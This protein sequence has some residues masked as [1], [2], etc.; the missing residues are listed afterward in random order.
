M[1]TRNGGGKP[2]GKTGWE[3]PRKKLAEDWDGVGKNLE[4]W[5]GVRKILMENEEQGWESHGG[6]T[7]GMEGVG[8]GR[9]KRGENSEKGGK[10]EWEKGESH[11]G[12][13]GME[14]FGAGF[15]AGGV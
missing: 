12:K 13:P 5:N 8:N 14:G 11:R 1:E 6:K 7:L 10:R 4:V 2:R 3:K 15:G 9:R